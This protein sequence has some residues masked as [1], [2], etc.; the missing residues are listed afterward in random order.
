MDK[1]DVNKFL[2]IEITRLNGDSFKLSQPF[3]IDPIFDFLG[4]CNNKFETDANS[5]ST[6]VA[7]GLLHCDFS[8]K[9]HKNSWKHW[10]AVGMLS[11][12]QNT[13]CTKILMAMHQTA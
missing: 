12:L 6:P 3:L 8:G 7:K 5:L 9:P 10:M 13:S 4:L 11:Y 1:G 2:G